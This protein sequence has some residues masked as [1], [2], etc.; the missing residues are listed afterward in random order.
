MRIGWLSDSVP[1]KGGAELAADTLL[2]GKP[3]DIEIVPCMP[4]AIAPDVDVYAIHNCVSYTARDWP[5]LRQKPI[6]KYVHDVWPRGDFALRTALCNHSKAMIFSSPIH[7]ES[8][9]FR[10]NCEAVYLPNPIDAKPFHD[11]KKAAIERKHAALWLGRFDIGKGIADAAV[12]AKNN[13]VD[14]DWYGYGYLLADVLATGRYRGYVDYANVP[15]IMAQYEKFVLLPIHC[16]PYGRVVAEAWLAGCELVINGNVG[17]AWWIEN[18]PQDVTRGV[19][20][21]WQTVKGVL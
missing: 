11:A 12:W 17:A 6:V 8:L 5:I 18:R 13:A 15:G 4:N 2:Q 1:I 16:E 3:E 20:L 14:M 21:F 19:E 7:R 9:R 10:V